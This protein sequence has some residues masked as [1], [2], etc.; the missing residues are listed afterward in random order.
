MN[1][2]NTIGNPELDY[3]FEEDNFKTKRKSFRFFGLIWFTS[4]TSSLTVFATAQLSGPKLTR[5]DEVV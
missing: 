3:L 2:I 1:M 5:G 4:E